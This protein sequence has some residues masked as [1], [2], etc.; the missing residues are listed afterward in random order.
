MP[1]SAPEGAPNILYI[2]LDDVG[3]GWLEPFGGLINTPNL[4][5]LADDGL[6][7]THF[8]TTALC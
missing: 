1:P 4:S 5:R 6:R 3:Y 8:T 2:I 7:Y